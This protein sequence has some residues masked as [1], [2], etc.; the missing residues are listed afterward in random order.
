MGAT[1]VGWFPDRD[2]L[3]LWFGLYPVAEPLAAQALT[4]AVM[5]M[6]GA[7]RRVVSA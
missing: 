7:L 5:L 3:Q 1:P 6:P 2:W 4:L